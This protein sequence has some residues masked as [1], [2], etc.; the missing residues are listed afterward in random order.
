MHAACTGQEPIATV[1]HLLECYE[2]VGIDN[3]D[4]NYIETILN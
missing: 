4:P 2:L 3:A 1:K